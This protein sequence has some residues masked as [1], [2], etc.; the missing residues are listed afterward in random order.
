MSSKRITLGGIYMS[1][2]LYMLTDYSEDFADTREFL[3]RQVT[4]AE[5]AGSAVG[6]ALKHVSFPLSSCQRKTP[7]VWAISAPRGTGARETDMA[8]A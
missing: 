3:E 2:E 6:F 8:H 5:K 1:A 7:R 4:D